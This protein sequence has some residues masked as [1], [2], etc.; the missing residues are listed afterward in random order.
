MKYFKHVFLALVAITPVVSFAAPIFNVSGGIQQ[1]FFGSILGL[2]NGALIPIVVA[3]AILTFLYGLLKLV[4]AG[5]DQEKRKEATGTIIWG[6]IVLTVMF[7]LYGLIRF[8]QGTFGIGG[9]DSTGLTVPKAP[10]T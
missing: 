7:S 3:L 1:D 6:I 8:V 10:T 9:N 4:T 2:I 5:G